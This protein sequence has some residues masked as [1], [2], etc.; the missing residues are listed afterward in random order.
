MGETPTIRR[1]T[2]IMVAWKIDNLP[3]PAQRGEA[4]A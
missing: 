3:R 4:A 1:D 2:A